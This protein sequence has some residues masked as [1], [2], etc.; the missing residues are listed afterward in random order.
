M[1]EGVGHRDAVQRVLPHAVELDRRSDAQD[2]VERGR[3]V[4][5]VVE[6]R[7]RRGVGPDAARP[8]HDQRRARAAEVCGD[9][10][11]ALERRGAGPGPAR[12]VH[13]VGLAPAQCVEAA[14]AFQQLEVLRYFCGDAVLRQQLD[15]GAVLSFGAAAVVAE[16]EEHQRVV[17]QPELLQLVDDLADLRIGVLQEAGVDLH[18]PALER[19]LGLGNA[20]PAG[21]RLG[22]GRELGGL[23]DPA[24]LLLAREGAF[25][26]GVPAVVELALVLVGPFLEDVV[27]AVHRAGRPVHQEGLV[28]RDGAVAAQP[29]AGLVGHVLAQVVALAARRLD[30]RGVLD[31]A[32]LVL[33][34]LAAQ[35]AV[36]VVEAVA[37]GPAVEGAHLRGQVGRRVVPLAERG[38][39]VAPG[40]EHL[41]HRA[42]ALGNDAHVAVPVGGVLGDVAVAHAVRVAPRQQRGARG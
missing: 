7:A 5:D 16:H 33:R 13:V 11:G 8:R 14:Q 1:G 36:E 39:V 2:V 41:G 3:D 6:L 9:Q 32:R 27:R 23:G 21:E 15:H 24:H 30:E 34:A 37:G 10:L 35:E 25:A 28:G 20:V 12:V 17:A 22:P 19:A 42:G 29:A 18:Q 38:R 40:P 26:V 4:V 31:Q